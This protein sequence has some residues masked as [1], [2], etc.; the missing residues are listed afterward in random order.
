M[1]QSGRSAGRAAKAP[2][3][4]KTRRRAASARKTLLLAGFEPFGKE[5]IN[6]S[7]EVARRLDGH[8]VGEFQIEAMRLPVVFWR[9]TRLLVASIRRLRPDAVLGLGQAGGRTSICIEQIAI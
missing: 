3:K 9:A 7:W 1:G 8:E 6:P 4:S 2:L 5:R